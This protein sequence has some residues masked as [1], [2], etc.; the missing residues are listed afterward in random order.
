LASR[1]GQTLQYVM[2]KSFFDQEKMQ[3]INE[4]DEEKEEKKWG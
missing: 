2:D 3:K 4:E 1:D